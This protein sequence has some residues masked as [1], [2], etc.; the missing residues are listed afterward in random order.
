MTNEEILAFLELV[1]EECPDKK[2]C[3]KIGDFIWKFRQQLKL[4]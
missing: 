4:K 1:F 2:L 3:N